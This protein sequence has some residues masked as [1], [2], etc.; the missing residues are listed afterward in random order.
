[1][2][3]RSIRGVAWLLPMGLL[4]LTLTLAWALPTQAQTLPGLNWSDD[5][6][7][8]ELYGPEFTRGNLE[9]AP[10]FLDGRQVG[11]VS[12]FIEFQPDQDDKQSISYGAGVRSQLIQSKLQKILQLMTRYSQDVLPNQGIFQIEAQEKEL[13]EQLV[14]QVSETK[15]TKVVLAT[16]PKDDVPEIIYSVTEAEIARPR[17][18]GSQP[19]TIAE[20]A[21]TVIENALIRAW[22]ERQ[23]AYLLDQGRR[24][25]LVLGGL[26]GASLILGWGQ[27]RLTIRQSKLRQRL[28][29]SESVQLSDTERFDLSKIAGGLG[30][31]APKFQNLSLMLRISLTALYKSGLFWTQ[32]LLWL[33]GIVYL[34]SLFHWTRPFSNWVSGVTIRGSW[35]EGPIVA[36]WPPADWLVSFGREATL[37]TPLYILLLLLAA[38]LTIKGIDALIDYFAQNW[39]K[40]ASGKRYSLR[41]PTLAQAFKG[42]LRTIVY[43]LLGVTILY[44]LHQLGAITRLA[45]VFLGFF[46]FALSLASQSLL[47]DLIAGV[48]ILWEDQYTV[49]DVVSI[50]EQIGLVEQITLRVTQLRN[51]DGEL[52][53]VPNGS[54]G[55]VRNLSSEWSRVNYAIEVGYEADV[56]HVLQVMEAVG[57]DLYRDPQW[58]ELILEAPEILGVDNIAHT[59]ILIRL[60]IKTQPLQ[61]WSV[62]REYRRRLKKVLDQQ[63]IRVGIPQRQMMH[64]TEEDGMYPG[65]PSH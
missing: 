41:T 38:R 64:V 36:G 63:G 56:D 47:K 40:Q 25:L 18:S 61:Q 16:F 58:Q 48:L 45:A 65:F 59:G 62:A 1:M 12:S 15:G 14:L 9:I 34:S 11:T 44:Y 20:H 50:S 49:G 46:S 37:G 19:L 24:V 21:A 29:H 32:W 23:T 10:V 30:M 54:I 27:K 4:A 26:T 33:L 5:D 8:T 42:W 2:V 6:L 43:L 22:R 7:P 35:G 3:R 55:V 60:I 13:R 52:I 28:S 53:T 57:Q 31:T 17:L 51:L 39:S